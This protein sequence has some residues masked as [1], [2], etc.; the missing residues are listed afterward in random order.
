MYDGDS[1]TSSMVFNELKNKIR[2]LESKLKE[3]RGELELLKRYLDHAPIL[4][5]VVDASNN[6]ILFV[7]KNMAR[8]LGGRREDLVGKSFFEVLPLE[9]SIRRKR[10]VK[11]VIE[12]GEIV[13]FEDKRDGRW[14]RNIG[15]PIYDETGRVIQGGAIVEEITEEKKREKTRLEERSKYFT[16]IIA[17]SYEVILVISKDGLIRYVSPS[18]KKLFGYSEYEFKTKSF[19]EYIHID[20]RERVEKL[21][22]SLASN[23]YRKDLIVFRFLHKDGS[24][25]ECEATLVDQTGDSIIQGIIVAIRDVSKE[26]EI[27]ELLRESEEKYRFVVE[28]SRA[29]ISILD[30]TGKFLFVNSYG[31]ELMNSTPS[32]IIGKRMDEVFPKEFAEE[33]LRNLNRILESKKELTSEFPVHVKGEERWLLSKTKPILDEKGSVKFL[34]N[35]SIDITE[36]KEIEKEVQR[37]KTYLQNIIDSAPEVIFTIGSDYR[38]S[39]W[40]NA[41]EHITGYNREYIIG[42]FLK[43]LDVFR[44]SPDFT[45]NVEKLFHGEEVSF[46]NLVLKAKDGSRRILQISSSPIYDSKGKVIGLLFIG[47]ISSPDVEKYGS[48]LPGHSYLL[49]EEASERAYQLFS[50]MI[51]KGYPGLIIT[52]MHPDNLSALFPIEQLE[53]VLL[54]KMT[55]GKYPVVSSLD[56]LYRGI[57]EFV[58][59]YSKGIIFLDRVDYLFSLFSFE[60]VI[61]T[62]YSITEFIAA[63]SSIFLLRVDF[64]SLSSKQ[65][66]LLEQEFEVLPATKINHLLIDEF[67]LKILMYLERE[68]KRN[69]QATIRGVC[70]E[71]NISRVTAKRKLQELE[72]KNLVYSKKYGRAKVFYLTE[73]GYMLLRSSRYPA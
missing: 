47:R 57:Q 62:F 59:E 69:I 6:R 45:V 1:K 31:A 23:S 52:R 10:Y 72:N 43:S 68:N 22:I 32:E 40:N 20:D 60:E 14:F 9:A 73:R 24:W 19:L 38:I 66:A 27:R 36:Q 44:Y 16:N 30:S 35:L 4:S 71:L 7:N 56:D 2:E 13:V 11:D 33:R 41:A 65:V 17:H 64:T 28:N 46:D 29:I 26:R 12:K 18:I 54:Q 8:S 48:L 3:T 5:L 61:K 50:V 37:T 34:L 53:V 51:S 39:T 55:H 42:R 15:F 21:L 70:E 63:S 49:R 67:S 25:L 58:K